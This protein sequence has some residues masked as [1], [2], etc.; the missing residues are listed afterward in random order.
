MLNAGYAISNGLA[1]ISQ[2]FNIDSII[3]YNTTVDL[4][5]S[6]NEKKIIM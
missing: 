1:D 2:S 5:Y 6:N 4:T 3:S